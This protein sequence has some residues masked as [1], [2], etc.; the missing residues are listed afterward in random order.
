MN[1]YDRLLK[2]LK[3]FHYKHENPIPVNHLSKITVDHEALSHLP[4]KQ[5]TP[6]FFLKF[7]SDV[8]SVAAVQED[9]LQKPI[10]IF[11]RDQ[12]LSSR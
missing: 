1:E 8:P 3:A 4:V 12:G 9:S 7:S 11:L 5:S 2:Y 10:R 6:L